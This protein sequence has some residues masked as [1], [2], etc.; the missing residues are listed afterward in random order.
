[1]KFSKKSKLCRLTI[2]FTLGI[3][4]PL[5]VA[6]IIHIRNQRNEWRLPDTSGELTFSERMFND[7]ESIEKKPARIDAGA[8]RILAEQEQFPAVNTY[9]EAPREAGNPSHDQLDRY[10]SSWDSLRIPELRDPQSESNRQ[11]ANQLMEKRRAR[12][13]TE[14]SNPPE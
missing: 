9:S 12:L 8:S 11:L 10:V 4:I 5:V 2:V 14:Q 7:P 6:W 13:V 3:G 1:M